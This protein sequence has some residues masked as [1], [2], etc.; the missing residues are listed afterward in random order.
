ARG[1]IVAFTDA[2]CLAQPDW[3]V[4]LTRPFAD[5]Q[6]A[7]VRGKVA[8]DAPVTL[9]EQFTHQADPLGVEALG[10]LL[11][12]ITANV[13]Y[14]RRILEQV[15]GFRSEMFTGAD[16]DLGWRVQQLPGARVVYAETAVVNHKHRTTL[17]GLRRQYQRYG[18]SEVMLD[19]LYRGQPFYRR[20]P[21]RQVVTMARQTAALFRYLLS[22][23]YRATRSLLTGWDRQYVL[24]PLLWL[25][26][27]GSNL[28]GKI[29]ALIQTRFFTR[30]P[31]RGGQEVL[32]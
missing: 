17:S 32:Q 11:S 25:A 3:L 29:Q 24:W 8:S 13:A 19:A 6:V 22:F 2:D 7:G 30:H 10:G 1:E 12:M 31:A 5:P 18:F 28:L 26:A 15:G 21:R 20:S 9:V 16:V 27:D 14:R 23:V 4:E